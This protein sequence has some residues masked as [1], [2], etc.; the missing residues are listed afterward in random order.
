MW[1]YRTVPT[2]FLP[3]EDQGYFIIQ[4]QAPEGASLE[5]TSNIGKQAEQVLRT[6]PDVAAA[7]TVGGFSFSGASPNRGLLF[8]RLKPYDER[9]NDDA[10]GAGDRRAA[11]R[12]ADRRHQRR[13]RRAVPAAADP[14]ARRVRRVPV[15]GARPDGRPRSRTSPR[16]RRT[17]CKQGNRQPELRGLFT[18]FTTGDP[19]LYVDIDRERVKSL[20]MPLNEVTDA[21]QVF[22]GSQYVNDFDFNNRAYRVYV[23]ADQRFRNDPTIAGAVLRAGRRGRD[24]AAVEPGA[25]QGDD[26][27]A[28]H[29]PLQPVPLGGDQ[30]RR[31]ARV[32]LG[33]GAA[34]RCRSSRRRTLPTGMTYAWAGQSLE[35]IKAGSQAGVIFALG[36]LLVYLTLAAQYESFLLPFIILLAVPVAVLGA[37]G[38]QGLRGLANDIYCQVGL[39]MLIGLAAKNAILI[40]EFA[41]QLRERGLSIAEAAI[42]A[43]R[44]R[45]RPILMTS[46]AFILGVLPLVFA[47]GA[48][49]AGRHSVGTAVFGG[50]LVSTLPQPRLHPR[51]LC[52]RAHPGARRPAR[53]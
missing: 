29:Q 10:V 28:G 6:E 27:A 14:R 3:D 24:G 38:A 50:M 35:E 43:A 26:R 21:L 30:R 32:Q 51:A 1:V 19:Q 37:V 12:H 45:L 49:E 2:A 44:I 25:R 20:N 52:R 17:W 16:P 4:M 13:D 46:F 22:L 53:R 33:S 39:V 48:G 40:V 9:R 5:Y 18:S 36:L 8:V 41:E 7:F 47:Q 34:A 11:A 42:E 15:R 31:G 23:Q